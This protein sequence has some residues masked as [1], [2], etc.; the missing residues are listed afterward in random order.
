M[1]LRAENHHKCDRYEDEIET[2]LL[3]KIPRFNSTVRSNKI[4][5]VNDAT[6]N[7]SALYA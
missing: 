4:S 1:L 5:V 2:A 7:Y 3:Q 6:R